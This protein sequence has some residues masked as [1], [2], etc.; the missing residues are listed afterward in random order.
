MKS[1]EVSPVRIVPIVEGDGEVQAVPALIRRIHAE[2]SAGTPLEVGRPVRVKRNRVLHTGELERYLTLAG[3]LAGVDGRILVLLDANGDCPAELGPA[4]VRRARKARPD[5]R[6]EVVIAQR[7]YECWFLAAI[8]S[9]R[10]TRSI[11][12]DVSVPQDPESIR[13]AKE[14]LRARMKG[15]YSPTADQTALTTRFDMAAARRRSRS[16][17]RMWRAVGALLQEPR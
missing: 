9:L 13:G 4:I 17:G 11:P 12:P 7:E 6:V 1:S 10:G 8:D 16:F 5:R 2:V 3:N 14:W 15:R